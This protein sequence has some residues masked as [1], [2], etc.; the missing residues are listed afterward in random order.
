MNS[1][2]LALVFFAAFVAAEVRAQ[3][4]AIQG[5]AQ[6]CVACHGPNG[7]S[8]DPQYPILAGQTA[9]YIFLELRDFKAGRRHDPQ[10]DPM[11]GNLTPDDMLA[12]GDYFSKQ[13]K[14]PNGF[15]AD[16]GKVALGAKKSD[17]V[18]CTMCHGGG[19]LGQNEIPRVAGQ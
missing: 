1:A 2:L 11:A 12:L 9:R 5:K 16:G 10:M 19:F 17:E 7:N 15:N 3:A 6:V 13:T 14:A 18:L 4:D 8:R